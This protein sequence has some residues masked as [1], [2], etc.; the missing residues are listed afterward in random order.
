M[1]QGSQCGS[2]A[3]FV[4]RHMGG[5]PAPKKLPS[6]RETQRQ[7]KKPEARA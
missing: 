3:E 6:Y 1:A 7:K 5:K 2:L 4:A